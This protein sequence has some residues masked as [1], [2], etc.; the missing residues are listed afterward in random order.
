MGVKIKDVNRIPD[1]IKIVEQFNRKRIEIGVFGEKDSFISMIATVHEF[2]MII[3][4][5]RGKFLAIPTEKAR[6]KRPR[7]FP[8]LVFVPTRDGKSGLLI[9]ETKGRGP[10]R[11]G[12]RTDIYF[13][14]VRSVKIPERSFVRSTFDEQERTWA[15]A[16]GRLLGQVFHGQ[17]S[18]DTLFERLGLLIVSDIQRTIR[19]INDPP[20]APITSS[21]KKS[22]NPLIDSG[23][24]RQSVTYR[25]VTR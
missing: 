16:I 4:P 3:R 18:I 22:S 10:G 5:K 12:A 2:G 19:E 23:R 8:D 11:T 25:V 7:D 14:L 15:N 9:R 6:D 17:I 1:L 24:M 13:I 21:R 20:N